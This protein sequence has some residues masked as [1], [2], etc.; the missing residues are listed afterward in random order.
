M[1][2]IVGAVGTVILE[3]AEVIDEISGP[4]VRRSPAEDKDATDESGV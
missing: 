4:M 3:T 2:G 1:F